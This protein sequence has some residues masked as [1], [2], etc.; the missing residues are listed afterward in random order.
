MAVSNSFTKMAQLTLTTREHV[1]S[2]LR[3]YLFIYE[4]CTQ[5]ARIYASREHFSDHETE[6]HVWPSVSRSGLCPLSLDRR[7]RGRYVGL[8]MEGIAFT[9]GPKPYND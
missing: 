4:E 2:D 6:T 9:V 7:D 1:M 5:S 8:H 3:P